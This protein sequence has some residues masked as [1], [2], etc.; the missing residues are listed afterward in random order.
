MRPAR[1]TLV[2]VTCHHGCGAD[3]GQVFLKCLATLVGRVPDDS[4]SEEHTSELPVTDVSRM[5]SS[6]CKNNETQQIARACVERYQALGLPIRYA[7]R[8][9]R[10]VYKAGAL[11]EGL[12]SAIFFLMI[13]RPPD[14]PPFPYIPLFT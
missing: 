2:D 1:G 9:D 4:R 13:S 10:T 12:D 11:A 8:T 14:F 6:A 3:L 5:P 7:H